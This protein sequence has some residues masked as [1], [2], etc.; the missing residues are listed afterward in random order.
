MRAERVAEDQRITNS[1][2]KTRFQP[3]AECPIC[4]ADVPSTAKACPNCGADERTGWDEDATRYDGVD[5]PDLGDDSDGGSAEF[6]EMKPRQLVDK[7]GRTSTGVPV[8]TWII[9][10]LLLVFFAALVLRGH[11]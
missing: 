9:A 6:G 3:P 10:C 1:V 5:L 4:G 11:F 2:T 7:H 8:L